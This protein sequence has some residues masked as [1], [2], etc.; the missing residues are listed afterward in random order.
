[1]PSCSLWHHCNEIQWNIGWI[2]APFYIFQ[3]QLLLCAESKI[4]FRCGTTEHRKVLKKGYYWWFWV[5]DI[6]YNPVALWNFMNTLTDLLPGLRRPR[7]LVLWMVFSDLPLIYSVLLAIVCWDKALTNLGQNKMVYCRRHFQI[8]FLGLKFG[9]FKFRRIL[10]L[11]YGM[12]KW[13]KI[14]T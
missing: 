8:F 6:F 4:F 10:L 13:K 9:L 11:R 5:N 3:V 7:V 12:P 1:M 14:K 2:Q